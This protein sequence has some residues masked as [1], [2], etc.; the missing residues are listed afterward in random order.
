MQM[1]YAI[2]YTIKLTLKSMCSLV[3]KYIELALK[4]LT[5]FGVFIVFDFKNYPQQ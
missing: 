2:N 5:L 3:E 1:G 4:I